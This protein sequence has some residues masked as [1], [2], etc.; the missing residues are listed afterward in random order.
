MFDAVVVVLTAY[1]LNLQ[2]CC[3]QSYDNASPMSGQYAGLQALILQL[4]PLALYVPCATHSLNLV[5]TSAVN[6]ISAGG[7]L[8][9]YLEDFYTF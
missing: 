4:C 3:V 5:G 2:D 8:F 1:D 9:D 6:S 7:M